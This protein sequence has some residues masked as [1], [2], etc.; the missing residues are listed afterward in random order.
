MNRQTKRMLQRQGQLGADG[1]PTARRAPAA[2][3][4]A[5]RPPDPE[6][7]SLGKR[8]VQYLREVRGELAKVLWPK[9]AEVVNYSTVVLTTLVFLALLI[10][11]LNYLF[12]RGVQFLFKS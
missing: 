9:R 6:R 8:F 7:A 4:P 5:R 2:G 12:A 1:A 3:G 10:F 11:G